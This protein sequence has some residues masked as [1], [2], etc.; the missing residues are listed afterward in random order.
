MEGQQDPPPATTSAPAATPTSNQNLILGIVMGAVVLLLLLLVITQQF[1]GQGD[2]TN[3]PKVTEMQRES[4]ELKAKIALMAS[5]SGN[6]QTTTLLVEGIKRDV[7]TLG[8]IVEQNQQNVLA[9]KD[10]Q[11][12][13]QG[14]TRQLADLQRRDKLNGDA[15][16]R[17]AGLE[18]QVKDLTAKLDGA[19]DQATLTAL[20]DQLKASKALSLQLQEELTALE[21]KSARMIDDNQHTAVRAELDECLAENILLKLEL[22]KLR[23]KLDGAR[24]FVTRENLSPKAQKFFREL[25]RLEGIDRDGLEQA[26]ERI[27]KEFNAHVV[28]TA[29]FAAGSPDLKQEHEAHIKGVTVE[30]NP[31]SFFLVVGY[32][33]KTGDIKSNRDLSERRSKRVASTVNYLKQNSQEVQAV[34]LGETDRF[35][36]KAQP[37][38]ICE[39]WEIRP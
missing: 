15:T 35:G 39:V 9:L 19:V 29:A 13:V 38:Q 26:Y 3:D 18:A 10:S 7:G 34:Y 24:L 8:A 36:E 11:A 27:K 16:A 30:S 14:L 23:T 17:V 4:A 2:E 28:E 31:N 22:Q 37:N 33:S 25:E 1:G 12:T 21:A 5:T 6:N 32:A 20:R